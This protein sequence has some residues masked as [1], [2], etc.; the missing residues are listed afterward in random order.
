MEPDIVVVGAGLVEVG[1]RVRTDPVDG[2]RLDRA[3]PVP[4]PSCPEVRPGRS[5]CRS[6]RFGGGRHA[7]G[8]RR[9]D[10]RVTADTT[11]TT[12]AVRHDVRDGV[13]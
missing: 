11:E 5:L 1:G 6:V 3:F 12:G 13:R 8:A 10:H 7:S 9:D 4:Q 2:F